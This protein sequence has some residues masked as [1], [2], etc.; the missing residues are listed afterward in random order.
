MPLRMR[1]HQFRANRRRV[2]LFVAMDEHRSRS[3]RAIF[4]VAWD[5]N[6][7]RV[8]GCGFLEDPSGLCSDGTMVPYYDHTHPIILLCAFVLPNHDSTRLLWPPDGRLLDTAF[9]LLAVDR[10]HRVS[11]NVHRENGSYQGFISR[12]SWAPPAQSQVR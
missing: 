10:A 7:E 6:S 3:N 9:R 2:L 4:F 8:R 1:S 12:R 11:G 5:L